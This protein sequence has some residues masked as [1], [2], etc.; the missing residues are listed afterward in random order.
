MIR[1]AKF[2]KEIKILDINVEEMQSKL[3]E[4]NAEFKGKKEQKI[5]VYDV[6]TLYYRYLEIRE[7]L[8]IDNKLLINTNILKLKNL[9]IEYKDLVSD[10]NIKLIEKELG[11]NNIEDILNKPLSQIISF[12]EN[13]LVEESFSK[14]KI[15]P[16][17]WIRLRESNSEITM[18]SKHILEK[19]NSKYQ[20]V[21]ETEFNVSN[22]EEA[23]NFLESIGIAKRSYQ[24][25][26]RYSY[27]YGDAEIEI[28]IWPMLSP[29][30]EIECDDDDLIN[31]LV[32]K[33]NLNEKRIVSLNTEQLYREIGIDVHSISE[34][35]F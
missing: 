4:I 24:E 34:L 32:S 11:L 23:N 19:E 8:K 31:E 6:P 5:Y 7:L 21:I 18:T 25:K 14:L 3:E 22:I 28:D 12:L 20:N 33:L 30:M 26:I 35:K 1:M 17:K 10:E 16:N 2:E 29:Y 9:M 27:V 15:N 13:K